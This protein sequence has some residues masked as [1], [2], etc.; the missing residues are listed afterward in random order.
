MGK[1]KKLYLAK[2]ML[3][4]ILAA[5]MSVTMIPTTALAAPADE[6]AVESIVNDAAEGSGD[7]NVPEDEGGSEDG[8]PDADAVDGAT[9]DENEGADDVTAVG[10]KTEVNAEGDTPASKPVYEI[11]LSNS[12]KSEAVYDGNYHFASILRDVTLKKDGSPVPYGEND[13]VCTWKQK[14]ADGTYADMDTTP[15]NAGS[16]QA[17]LTYDG[18]EPLS[19]DCEIT[20]A[21]VTVVLTSSS[22]T[23]KPGTLR[24]KVEVPE[25]DSLNCSGSGLDPEH[26][27]LV[28]NKIR[29][30][31]TNEEVAAGTALKKNGDYVM[32]LTPDFS[33]KASADQKNNYVLKPFTADIKM[34]ALITTKITV[35]LAD[36]W[37][38]EGE[39]EAT[40]ITKD[41]DGLAM[42][43]TVNTDFTFEVFCEDASA[44][45]G[46]KKLDGAEVTGE[47]DTY[48]GCEVDENGKVKAP[49]DAGYYTY[50]VVYQG[51]DG[52]YAGSSANISVEIAQMKLTVE[53][54]NAAPL[55]VLE[56]TT[57][58]EALSKIEYKVFD[59]NGKDVTADVKAK[60]IW[61]TSYD[62]YSESQ[63]Y[64]PLFTMQVSADDGTSWSD[65]SAWSADE[66]LRADRKYRALF[67]GRK[68]V[69]EPENYNDLGYYIYAGDI[70]ER[71]DNG[72]DRNYYTNT[73][74]AEGKE[75][76]VQVTPGTEAVIDVSKL[77]GDKLGASSIEN[78][79]A[80]K[81]YDGQRIFQTRSQY[82]EK[83]GLKGK[84]DNAEIKTEFGEFS[85][86]WEKYD[87]GDRIDA[88]VAD[89]NQ[90]TLWWDECYML[91]PED[92]GVYR[93][94]IIYEDKIDD[95]KFYYVKEPAV[96]YFAI[97]P[98][99]VKLVPKA[100]ETP[101]EVME[102]S[103]AWRFFDELEPAYDVKDPAGAAVTIADKSIVPRG[104]IVRTEQQTAPAEPIISYYD[105][106]GEYNDWYDFEKDGTRLSY[107]LYGAELRRYDPDYYNE[108]YDYYVGYVADPNY[109]CY[110]SEL[111]MNG[112]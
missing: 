19:V 23:V 94:T 45:D 13:I 42:V 80:V 14:G 7:V 24:E 28:V 74:T 34:A 30:A 4:M 84:A 16:Y 12:F 53:A 99:Q 29:N 93:L 112:S 109:T 63:I 104:K 5:A 31:V 41:Y 100:P 58:G 47:W 1:T 43:P 102:G 95:G 38:Q 21:P 85:Y 76:V 82:K 111:V 70:N 79:K 49:I 65:I 60:H 62:E 44:G 78:L 2:R 54:A 27:T 108:D 22:L 92:A 6:D 25:I 18:A 48:T 66:T 67:N 55:T 39:T 35:K 101:Y 3:A 90:Q 57:V 8:V 20:K 96:V 69:F 10:G 40:Q 88:Q 56:G 103:Y 68:A 98:K 75:L 51:K 86:I 87:G 61:G 97:D 17:V 71:Y 105:Q 64:E 33:D 77:L 59:K 37:R 32:D 106:D 9:A 46:W 50:N 81:E 83:V 52:V 107:Q 89:K 72:V 110:S 36:K 11:V 91:S 15:K 73:T 26:V